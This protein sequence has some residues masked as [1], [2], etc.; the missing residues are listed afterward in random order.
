M[1]YIRQN[2][3][4]ILHLSRL[5]YLLVLTGSTAMSPILTL[6]KPSSSLFTRVFGELVIYH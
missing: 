1:N 3:F 2:K 4:T 5:F 6:V